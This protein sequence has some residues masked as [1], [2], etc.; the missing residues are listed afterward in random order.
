MGLYVPNP[1]VQ[2]NIL[3]CTSGTKTPSATNNYHSLTTN[4]VTITPGTW[5]LT[6]YASFS[7]SGSALYTDV[8]VGFYGTNGADTSSAPTTALSG[9]ANLTVDSAVTGNNTTYLNTASTFA[10][11][12]IPCVTTWVS[13][14]ADSTIYIVTYALMTTAANSRIT[15]R[16]SV[17]KIY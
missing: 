10:A 12:T 16:M 3:T 9:I 8:G 17:K 2:K 5:E 14:T 11:I 7:F 6:G 4:S 13:C 1:Y 15:A